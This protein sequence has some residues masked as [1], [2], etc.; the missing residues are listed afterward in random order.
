[1]KPLLSLQTKN[2]FTVMFTVLTALGSGSTVRAFYDPNASHAGPLMILGVG[3]IG[4]LLLVSV[5]TKEERELET[6]REMRDEPLRHQV[7]K[8]RAIS[9]RIILEIEAGNLKDAVRWDDFGKKLK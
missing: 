4:Q 9:E 5:P 1:M 6:L 2:L 8:G 3:V 7:A